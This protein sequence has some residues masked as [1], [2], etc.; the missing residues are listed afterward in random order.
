MHLP[1][2]NEFTPIN[3][4]MQTQNTTHIHIEIEIHTKPVSI[5]ALVAHR[6]SHRDG[7]KSFETETDCENKIASPKII[8]RI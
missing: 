4:R 5:L 3:K 8:Y 6:S 7:A 1:H 2:L